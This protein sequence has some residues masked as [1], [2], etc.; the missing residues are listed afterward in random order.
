M[1][2]SEINKYI[3]LTKV[4]TEKRIVTGIVLEPDTVD[5]Q[6]DIYDAGT[7]EKSAHD[8]LKDVRVVGLMHKTF[9]KDLHVVESYVAPVD[10]DLDGKQIKKGT[11]VM[12]AKVVDDTVWD[13]IKKREI[14]GFSIGAVAQYERMNG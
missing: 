8:F 13:A 1:N 5:L 12:A 4:E 7:I 3:P 9:G 6:G 2:T 11:W 10:F 14:T